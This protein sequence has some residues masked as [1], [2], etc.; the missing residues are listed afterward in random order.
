LVKTDGRS[1]RRREQE[2]KKNHKKAATPD[3][4]ESQKKNESSPRQEPYGRSR[5]KKGDPAKGKHQSSHTKTTTCKT[6][7]ANK[8]TQLKRTSPSNKQEQ[9]NGGGRRRKEVCCVGGSM[10]SRKASTWWP[11]G[12]V[13]WWITIQRNLGPTLKRSA[14]NKHS[15]SIISIIPRQIKGNRKNSRPL[16]KDE[17]PNF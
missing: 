12:S 11:V 6:P 8:T 17:K 9:N 14:G 4:T 15:K 13:R 5:T 16:K 2:E 1:W 10:T 7:K 3:F